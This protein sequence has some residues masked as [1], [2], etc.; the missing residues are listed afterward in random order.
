M[1]LKSF[2]IFIGFFT[3]LH[4]GNLLIYCVCKFDEVLIEGQGRNLTLEGASVTGSLLFGF[5]NS[6]AG[7]S[8]DCK[9]QFVRLF[10]STP[11]GRLPTACRL[12]SPH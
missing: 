3:I 11:S 10:R 2:R 8:F 6:F 5:H 1:E 9:D 4:Y 12:A 7:F